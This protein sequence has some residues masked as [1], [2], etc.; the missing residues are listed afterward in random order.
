MVREIVKLI[1]AENL[2]ESGL[3]HK[4]LGLMDKNNSVVIAGGRGV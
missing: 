1:L 3:N 4:K 2:N